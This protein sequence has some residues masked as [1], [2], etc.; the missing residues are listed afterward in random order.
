MKEVCCLIYTVIFSKIQIMEQSCRNCRLDG[1]LT[2]RELDHLA[3]FTS[4][5]FKHNLIHLIVP[6]VFMET[7]CSLYLIFYTLL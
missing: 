3:E 4:K 5:L 7:H 2:N 6:C 1:I